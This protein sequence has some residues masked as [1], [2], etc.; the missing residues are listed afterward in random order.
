MLFNLFIR[1]RCINNKFA[2]VFE[3][4]NRG[5]RKWYGDFI[6]Y[7]FAPSDFEGLLIEEILT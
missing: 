5:I 2:F 4:S 3:I 7:I 1:H 6:E